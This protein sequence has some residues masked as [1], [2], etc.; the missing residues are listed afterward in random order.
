MK[1]KLFVFALA[2]VLLSSCGESK[3]E[4]QLADAVD[5]FAVNYFNCRYREAMPFA[6]ADSKKWLQ[7]AA[8]QMHQ[9]DV[10]TLRA[11]DEGASCEIEDIS[12]H[13]DDTTASTT[14]NVFNFYKTDTIG[15]V[16]RFIEKARFNLQATRQDGAWKVRM[17]GL[18][19]NGM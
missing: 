12:I 9:T 17:E 14:V 4:Q 3:T 8:S 7:F 15:K 18:P 11:Q 1:F 13:D 19:Q 6:T 10:D 5:S 16:G 2:G